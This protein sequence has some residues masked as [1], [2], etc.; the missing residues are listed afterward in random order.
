MKLSSIRLEY[1]GMFQG[2]ELHVPVYHDN[3]SDEWHFEIKIGGRHISNGLIRF[4]VAGDFPVEN[5]INN[6]VLRFM[7][8]NWTNLKEFFEE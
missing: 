7:N 4:N 3:H 1:R 6:A 8:D 2:K 5:E